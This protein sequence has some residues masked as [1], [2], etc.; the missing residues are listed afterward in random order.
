M[1]LQSS[2][3]DFGRTACLTLPICQQHPL[4]C[5]RVKPGVWLQRCLLC[6]ACHC[7]WQIWCTHVAINGGAD[8]LLA[9]SC[10]MSFHHPVLS[11]KWT[12]YWILEAARAE[13][14]DA[15]A[16]STRE[17]VPSRGAG[18]AT[19]FLFC[20]CFHDQRVLFWS[21]SNSEQSSTKIRVFTDLK[22]SIFLLQAEYMYDFRR[23]LLWQV[24]N[25]PEM[26][27]A[28]SIILINK[29]KSHSVAPHDVSLAR[30]KPCSSAVS[31][32]WPARLR[33]AGDICLPRM[34][35]FCD[36]KKILWFLGP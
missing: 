7:S 34:S 25:K 4:F 8:F 11:L 13:I 3:S 22:I 18:Q 16:N 20:H 9:P 29:T 36:R 30:H 10:F 32:P 6:L 1:Q 33:D 14:A 19:I 26:I 2:I 35:Q 31:G 21:C 15:F 17:N 5:G 28:T 24:L 27:F 23:H 12:K